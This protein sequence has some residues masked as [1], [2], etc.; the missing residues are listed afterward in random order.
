MQHRTL[1]DHEAVL[2]A[3]KK[4]LAVSLPS[5]RGACERTGKACSPRD[6][7]ASSLRYASLAIG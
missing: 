3:G 1:Y 5:D 4:R 6:S 7:A 2:A